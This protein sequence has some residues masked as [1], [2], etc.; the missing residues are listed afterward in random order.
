MK[1][2]HSAQYTLRDVPESTDGRL[3]EVAAT[4]GTSLNRAAL[5]ALERGLGLGGTPVRYRSLRG[6]VN[7]PAAIDRKS[8][9]QTL[10][11]MDVVDPA[12]WETGAGGR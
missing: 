10:A 3:R 6:L 9:A 4:E 5:R 7:K 11:A 1:K 12:A 2:R 8:W